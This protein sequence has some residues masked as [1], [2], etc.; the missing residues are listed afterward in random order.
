MESIRKI[1]QHSRAKYWE[2]QAYDVF[3]E[4]KLVQIKTN[5]GKH[6]LVPYD[7]LVVAIGAQNA[8]FGV[9]GVKEN[10][11]FL[12]SIND[13]R[14]IRK[15][16][17][18]LFEKASLPVVSDKERK[19]LLSFVVA[20]GGPTGVEFAAALYD[21]LHEDVAKYFPHLVPFANVSIIQS[22]EHI[23][24][25]FAE[26]IST[27]AEQ[28]FKRNQINII[29][30]ARVTEVQPNKIIYKKKNAAPGETD[31]VELDFGLCVW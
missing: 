10:T 23:L 30:Q 4:K 22:S 9:P 24:N 3:P 25:A 28:R 29:T 13:A 21:F 7:K 8:T 31:I 18:N 14:K 5:D 19:K 17:M 26:S 1:C 11:N 15:E 2:G 27:F 16:M 6:F 20:G 12:K